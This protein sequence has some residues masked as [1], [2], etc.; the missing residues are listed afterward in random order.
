MTRIRLVASSHKQTGKTVRY[1]LLMDL[2]HGGVPHVMVK[3]YG[4]EQF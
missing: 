2:P 3:N 1:A 4:P